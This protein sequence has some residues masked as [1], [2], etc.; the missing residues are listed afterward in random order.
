MIKPE[1]LR[2]G[3]FVRVSSD[4]SMIPKGAVCEVVAIDSE[5]ECEDKKGLAGLLQ[6]VREEWEFSHGVWCDDIEGI[7][8]N[9]G[10]LRKNGWNIAGHNID[11]GGFEWIVWEHPESCVEIQFYPRTIDYSAFYCGEELCDIA[12]VHELQNILAS[13]KE[14]VKITI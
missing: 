2:I 1:D 4:N 7:P 12:Y 3:N 8:F 5:R 14:N 9:N 13:I 10:F 11:R 6:I